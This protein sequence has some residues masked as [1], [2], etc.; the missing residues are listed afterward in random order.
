M[1][2]STSGDV[3][4]VLVV[5]AWRDDD[6]FRARVT[7]TSNIANRDEEVRSFSSKADVERALKDWLETV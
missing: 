3:I 6:T 2:S 7:M 5:R 4:G 1:G